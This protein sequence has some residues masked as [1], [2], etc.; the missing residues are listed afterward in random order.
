MRTQ[1]LSDDDLA[2]A[3]SG[4]VMFTD[5]SP[6]FRLSNAMALFLGTPESD[7]VPWYHCM[8]WIHFLSQIY[9]SGFNV[10]IQSVRL[11]WAL[12]LTWVSPFVQDQNK[13]GFGLSEE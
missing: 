12:V 7:G 9:L 6:S 2:T 8:R 3:P 4:P 11:S 5:K 10:H 1:Y 13:V